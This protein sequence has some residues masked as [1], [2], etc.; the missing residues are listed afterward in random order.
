MDT[1]KYRVSVG[2]RNLNINR[3]DYERKAFELG[4]TKDQMVELTDVELQRWV[5]FKELKDY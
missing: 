2:T 4:M 5:I 3:L 1:S